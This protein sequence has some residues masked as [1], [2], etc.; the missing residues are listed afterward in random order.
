MRENSCNKEMILIIKIMPRERRAETGPKGMGGDILL[1]QDKGFFIEG[2]ASR[3]RPT[4]I[5]FSTTR[6]NAAGRG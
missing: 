4:D 1:R 5:S 6:W 2:Q 3:G